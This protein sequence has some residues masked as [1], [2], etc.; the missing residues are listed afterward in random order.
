[1][2]DFIL[3]DPGMIANDQVNSQFDLVSRILRSM[4]SW[5]TQSNTSLDRYQLPLPLTRISP[6]FPSYYYA[7]PCPGSLFHESRSLVPPFVPV[8]Q[9]V[10]ECETGSGV[11]LSNIQGGDDGDKSQCVSQ[12]WEWPTHADALTEAKRQYLLFIAATFQDGRSRWRSGLESSVRTM[13]FQASLGSDET[14]EPFLDVSIL[15]TDEIFQDGKRNPIVFRAYIHV[16]VGESVGQSEAGNKCMARIQRQ[17][18]LRTLHEQNIHFGPACR[19]A[20]RWLS[21]QLAWDQ[22]DADWVEDFIADIPGLNDMHSVPRVF[23]SWLTLLTTD[24]RPKHASRR[25]QILAK[26][27]L[28]LFDAACNQSS[29]SQDLSSALFLSKLCRL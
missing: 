17:A 1:M 25:V 20:K 22:S 2:F 11:I 9:I 8:H 6:N 28:D 14:N 16:P 7:D 18:R 5:N 29:S 26:A 13:N 4:P 24:A 3:D 15:N 10:L 27:S 12:K 19:V 21:S 23:L